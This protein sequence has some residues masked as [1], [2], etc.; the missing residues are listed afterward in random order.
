MSYY[1]TLS[2]QE[3][4]ALL[5]EGDEKAFTEIY[6]RYHS[7]LY[8]YA[9]KKLSNK[10]EAQDIIHEV[11]I[12]LWTRRFD[13]SMQTS[14]TSYLFS[15]VRNKALDL[16]SHKKVEA[17]YLASLQNFIADSG[18]QTDFLIREN[19]LKTLIEKE[20]QA[21]PPRMKEAFQLSRKEKL[22]H[23]EIAN[24]MDI[25][26]QTVST[27]IKKALRILRVRLGLII[28]LIMLL[29]NKF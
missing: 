27:Q 2:D 10:Q 6:E 19:D 12:T 21:L 22:S 11:L 28:Y 13:F 25:S 20:I 16:F 18:I 1:Q 8:I 26:E 17:K 4:T 5:H 29:L 7:L 23:K 3:L 14:L 9:H 15:A 24:L